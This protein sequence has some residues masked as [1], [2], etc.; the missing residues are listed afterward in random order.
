MDLLILT[1]AEM[2][3]ER[4]KSKKACTEGLA[5]AAAVKSFDFQHQLRNV[6]EENYRL[7]RIFRFSGKRHFTMAARAYIRSAELQ[8]FQNTPAKKL[9]FFN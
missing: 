4:Q 6:Q 3:H 9:N 8:H 7:V 2:G 1:L 5:L